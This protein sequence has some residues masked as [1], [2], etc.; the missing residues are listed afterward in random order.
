MEES[1]KTSIQLLPEKEF[2][3]YPLSQ[4]FTAWVIKVGRIVIIATELIAFAVF[5]GRI[6]LDREL[7]DLTDTLENQLAILQNAQDFENEF[8]DLQTRLKII[9]ELRQNQVAVSPTLSLFSTLLPADVELTDLA[10]QSDAADLTAKTSS[11]LSFA[12]TV[13]NLKNSL[14]VAE[15]ALTSGRFQAKDNTY[16][17][18]LAIKLE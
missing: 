6:K 17:F 14:E 9:G 12:R 1:E 16:Y 4:Q 18:S 15:I 5:I 8:I 13:N 11:P 3:E 2:E 7:T 10:L